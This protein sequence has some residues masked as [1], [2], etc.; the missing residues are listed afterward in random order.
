MKREQLFE[1]LEP[2]P[3]GLER[4]RARMAER[5]RRVS[6][7]V[8]V[9]VVAS[10]LVG[11]LVWPKTPGIDLVALARASDD[12]A[13][14][15]NL[16]WRRLRSRSAR[17]PNVSAK[18]PPVSRWIAMAMIIKRNS[19]ASMRRETSHIACSI[20]LPRRTASVIRLNSRPIGSGI[21]R[22]TAAIDSE[23]GKPERKPRHIVSIDS[24]KYLRNLATLAFPI[25]VTIIWGI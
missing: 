8:F 4:L 9:G 14:I 15:F 20:V 24:G 2:P 22:A 5:R 18:L 23:M 6:P 1:T 7:L 12:S 25:R 13:R 3:F 16:N 19:D 21:S 11:L 17:L 10:A